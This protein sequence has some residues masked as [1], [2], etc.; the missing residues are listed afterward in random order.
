MK[1]DTLRYVKYMLES[2]LGSITPQISYVIREQHT[3]FIADNCTT[4]TITVA[5]TQTSNI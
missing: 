1:Y 3:V 4:H 2:M 5:A